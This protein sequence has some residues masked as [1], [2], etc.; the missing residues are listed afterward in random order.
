[1][2]VKSLELSNL[3]FLITHSG[4]GCSPLGW[5]TIFHSV[6]EVPIELLP[7][8]AAE[9]GALLTERLQSPHSVMEIARHVIHGHLVRDPGLIRHRARVNHLGINQR[10]QCANERAL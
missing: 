3:L 2:L 6:G 7:S 8:F 9:L 4:P 5:V 1:M 10:T